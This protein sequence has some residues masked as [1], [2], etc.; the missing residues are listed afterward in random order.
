M[1]G[2]VENFDPILRYN[3]FDTSSVNFNIIMR[4]KEIGDQHLL[5]HEFIKALHE[6]Y[7]NEGIVIPYP[8]QTLD[9]SKDVLDELKS[10]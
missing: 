6:R 9:L 8:I 3:Q 4:V 10:R 5:K 2:A 1:P 7:K